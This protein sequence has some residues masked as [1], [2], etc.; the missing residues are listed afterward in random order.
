MSGDATRAAIAATGRVQAQRLGIGFSRICTLI[1]PRFTIWA[2]ADT[3]QLSGLVNGRFID[4]VTALRTVKR[5]A[6]VSADLPLRHAT[7]QAA[8]VFCLG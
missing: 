8:C 4:F 6:L 7:V 2:L 1:V 5:S 3:S